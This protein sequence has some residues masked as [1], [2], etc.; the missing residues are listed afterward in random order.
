MKV[1]LT[2]E[3][4][5][6]K[7]GIP[8]KLINQLVFELV[9]ARILSETVTGEEKTSAYQPA[10]DIEDLKVQDVIDAW[11]SY[12]TNSIPVKDSKELKNLEAALRGFEDSIAIHDENELL[13]NL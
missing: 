7:L 8:I 6:Q 11:E 9:Q 12:G 5:S 1:P 3:Q 13:K 10:R 4:L 2:S